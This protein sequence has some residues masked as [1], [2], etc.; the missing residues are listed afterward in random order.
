MGILRGLG[1]RITVKRVT[2]NILDEA[3]KRV[4]NGIATDIYAALKQLSTNA[5]PYEV[6]DDGSSQTLLLHMVWILVTR[7]LCFDPQ[8]RSEKNAH[9]IGEIALHYYSG[10]IKKL[11]K[12]YIEAIAKE[13][14]H[15]LINYLEDRPNIEE[16]E[17]VDFFK[18]LKEYVG[19]ERITCPINN[20][21]SDRCS[22]WLD[23]FLLIVWKKTK[24]KL[25]TGTESDFRIMSTV[26]LRE[27]RQWER[28]IRDRAGRA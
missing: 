14:T 1:L 24:E 12:Q 15:E 22:K 9:R 6:P 13:K 20:F 18:A 4:M 23:L 28:V 8:I 7:E 16:R 5:A 11:N 2:K 26:V 21:S 10:K 19:E 25:A 27:V 17:A 3:G